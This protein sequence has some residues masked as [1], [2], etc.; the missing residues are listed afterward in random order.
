MHFI[1]K[2]TVPTCGKEMMI[3][4]LSQP[5]N[6]LPHFYNHM[7]LLYVI[8]RFLEFGLTIYGAG[9]LFL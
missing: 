4:F 5:N 6:P 2:Y 8:I 7:F 9:L 1:W 3:F